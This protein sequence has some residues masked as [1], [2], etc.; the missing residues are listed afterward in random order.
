MKFI[1]DF[2]IHSH[3][4]RATSK[5][6]TPEY[7]NY[8][9]QVK[10]I[11]V[12]GTGDFTHPGW[13][14]EL[15]EKL[16]PI[17]QGLFKLKDEFKQDNSLQ[18]FPSCKNGIRFLL[19][20][21]ISNIYKKYGKVRKVHNLIFATNFTT[22]EK[23]QQKLSKIG[24]ITSDGR[25][26][27][28]LD[29][30]DLLEIVLECSDEAF[31]VPAHIWTPWFSALGS[32][33]GFNSISECYGDLDKHIFAVETG[34]SCYDEK[35]EILIDNSWK[36][37]SEVSYNDK[38]CTLNLETNEIEFQN[39]IGIFTYKYKGKMYRLKTK[40]VDLLVTPNHKLLVS[41]CDFRNPKPFSLKEAKFLFNK[42]KQF[43]K[44]GFW[45][46]ENEKYFTLPAV[47]IK[48]GSRYYSGFRVKKEK[49][50]PMKSWLKFFGFWIAEGWTTHWK[51]GDYNIC[52][53]NRNKILLLE[54]KQILQN[55]GYNVYQNNYTI[56]IRNFQLFHYLRQF[57][58]SSDK[59]IPSDIKSLSKELLEVLLEYYLKGDGYIYG[60]AKKG[61]SATTTSICLRDDLQEIALKIG[62][63]A[64]YKLGR[65]KGTPITSLG[66]YKLK[67]DAWQVYFIRKNRYTV[68]PS[69]IKKYNYVESWVD[70]NGSVFSVAVPN[71]VVYIRRNGIPVWCGNSDPPM[72]WMCSFLDRY[73]LISN[74]DA[75]SPEKLGRE[76]NLFDTEL[77]YNSIKEAMKTGNPKNF[78]C[79]IEFFP[80]E[81][82]YHYDGHRKCGIRWDPLKTLKHNGICPV[83]GKKVTIGVMN[84]VVQLA[85]RDDLTEKK[86]K[87]PFHSLVPLKEILSEILETGPQSMR[88]R[89]AYNSLLKKDGSEFELL[90]NLP[91][92]EI[93]KVGNEVLAE[94][95]R[96]MRNGEVSI[97]EGFDG[98]FG[99]IKVFQENEKREISP[100]KALFKDLIQ[101][102]DKKK[103]RRVLINFDLQ[104]Y[105]RLREVSAHQEM[106]KEKT[107]EAYLFQPKIN[108][109]NEL[110]PEQQ[111]AVEHFKG[112]ALIIA[113]PG[114]G[115]TRTL[116][117]RIASLIQNKRINPENILAVTFTNK[118]ANQM[119]ERLKTL[120]NN[121]SILSK[122]YISTFHAFG[123]SILKEYCEKFG[124]DEHFSI[125]DEEDKKQILS[126]KIG[127]EKKQISYVSD[128]I[129]SF[130][131]NLQSV[132]D[133][134]GDKIADKD[135]KEIF[136]K[137]EQILKEENAFDI[138]D[139]IYYP[140]R[141]FT[142]DSQI[143]SIYRKKYQ[144]IL[145]DEYQ[146]INFAQ[147]QM[148]KKLAPDTDANLC[149]IGDPNQAIYGFRGADVKFIKRFIDDYPDAKV[150]RLK[151]SYRC[152][153]CILQAS[154]QVIQTELPKKESMLEGLQKG[155]KI[156]IVENSTDKSEAEFV[157]RTIEKMMG[158]LR[159][160]SIDSQITG[161]EKESEIETLSDFAV[162]CRISRQM[163]QLEKAFND[164]SIPYQKVGDV[165]FFKQ[166]PIKSI[167]DFLKLSINPKNLFL[168]NRLQK[169]NKISSLE[170]ENYCESIKGKSVKN[171]I[172]DTIDKYFSEQKSENEVLIN[173]GKKLL[174]F[175]NDFDDN[176]EEFIKF[177]VLGTGVDTY[178]PNIENVT[179][180]T[181][182]AAKGLEFKCVFI[183]GCEDG[184]LPYSLFDD[185]KSDFNEECRLF[186]V[187]MTRAKQFLFLSHAKKRF[188]FGK[189]FHLEKSPY[190]SNIEKELIE[191]SKSEYKKRKR[192]DD[193]QT[194]LF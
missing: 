36:K 19:T 124:R 40:R 29:S 35:T 14:K 191:L 90:L 189:E 89:K 120:L 77:S 179:L 141:L 186:Y 125:F 1:A 82:K 176:L 62:I 38:I 7:L 173:R 123:L 102:R 45:T 69:T 157:A 116:T 37:F 162:L 142:D 113:G 147:Y 188:L 24:N 60:R 169:N 78:L 87:L 160:F 175:A 180:M 25:P 26:I 74:S 55:F 68:L 83:C 75:H 137:Y 13:L 136:T 185:Q 149:V 67:H 94:A 80:Q 5:R 56:R 72:N 2:H 130:K 171:A 148:L 96:R 4:S 165:P 73:T 167:I 131:Q 174:D 121:K 54:M 118:A 18:V 58:K 57:G 152:S 79:T 101:K 97:K 183:I 166:K 103:Q 146:D 46:G 12:I 105:R 95:I 187:G 181:L 92:E 192:K 52:L 128:K 132:P 134:L 129:T 112:P 190:L 154:S 15:K 164:H 110:N 41:T 59:F 91:I 44:D 161:G 98:E 42:S 47:K 104:E 76:A 145:V 70:F 6:L 155:V 93:K 16:Q 32:K 23:I 184:L 11:K 84:R 126:E 85:D 135:L 99:Q 43:K 50:L 27:L 168:K 170:L 177:A 34:L 64:Y 158:G 51:N 194:N 193:G 133:L 144:W 127:C 100:Q 9:A 182:H 172:K 21:E 106:V 163:K 61:V 151:K 28:G 150:Y 115:K 88:V 117:Y 114:T 111:K 122:L 53:S 30:R 159:F 139:L 178:R 39:P 71:H 66:P 109:L 17:E 81:G 48:H 65:R 138:D 33:S 49:K 63:S 31:L 153:D 107:E 119:K 8:W 22:A 20:A 108:I 86:N 156:K 143:L 10:G 140:V 3:Y